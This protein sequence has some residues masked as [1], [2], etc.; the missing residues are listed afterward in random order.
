MLTDSIQ[1]SGGLITEMKSVVPGEGAPWGHSPS[2]GCPLP[3]QQLATKSMLN[4][5]FIF[6]LFS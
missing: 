1:S 3:V 2:S 4:A 6:H 5:V